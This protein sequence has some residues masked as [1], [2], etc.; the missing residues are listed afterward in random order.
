MKGNGNP[1]SHAWGNIFLTARSRAACVSERGGRGMSSSAKA[2]AADPRTRRAALRRTGVPPRSSPPWVCLYP[3]ICLY[4][5]YK[6]LAV[7]WDA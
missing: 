7:T 6:E 3:D 2:V 4:E 1:A 5:G